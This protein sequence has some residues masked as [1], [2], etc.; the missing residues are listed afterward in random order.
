MII[1]EDGDH[2]ELHLL[3]IQVSFFFAGTGG[4]GDGFFFAFLLCEGM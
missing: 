1:T 2:Q 4:E 3:L